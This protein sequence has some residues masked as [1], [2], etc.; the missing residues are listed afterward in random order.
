M[1]LTSPSWVLVVMLRSL[2]NSACAPAWGHLFVSRHFCGGTHALSVARSSPLFSQLS[3]FLRYQ[4]PPSAETTIIFDWDGEFAASL[5]HSDDQPLLVPVGVMR[6]S[7]QPASY[8]VLRHQNSCSD[9]RRFS[10]PGHSQC[11]HV[12]QQFMVGTE[13]AAPRH[14]CRCPG[15][16]A[17]AAGTSPG[18][19]HRAA[20][21]LRQ[22][23]QRGDHHQRRD[24]LG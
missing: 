8:F 14:A 11:R 6:C 20:R 22:V 24:G 18:L 13:P 23:R 21:A 1:R 5:N 10:T 12:A 4:T 17:G 15:G 16:G 3:T 7:N 2:V 9:S 19:R